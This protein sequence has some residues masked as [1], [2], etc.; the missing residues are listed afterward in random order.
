M[1]RS[2]TEQGPICELVRSHLLR[3]IAAGVVLLTPV[4]TAAPDPGG[5]GDP[6]S[7]GRNVIHLGVAS[8]PSVA[9]QNNCAVS[10]PPAPARC[11]TL[12]AQPAVTNFTEAKLTVLTIPAK[13][14]NS[15]LCI[16]LTPSVSF[17]FHN[18]TGVAQPMARFNARATIQLDNE[19]LNDPTLIDPTTGQP[20]NGR[21]QLSIA[22]YYETR[23]MAVGEREHKQLFMTRHCIHGISRAALVESYGLPASVADDFFSHPL[24]LS[25][26]AAGEAQLVATATYYYGVRIYGDG[27]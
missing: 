8:T 4:V 22:T 19:I 10:P 13:S 15:L 1:S 24:T 17:L 23:N 9:F 26:G 16:V 3:L 7:F 11:V 6:D 21:L 14:T 12:N 18:Q 2:R 5:A 20:F 27:A 25:F